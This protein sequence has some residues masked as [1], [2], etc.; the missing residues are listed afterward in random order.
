MQW[1]VL[2]IG[3]CFSAS[4]SLLVKDGMTKKDF[5]ANDFLHL[6]TNWQIWASISL[7]GLAFILYAIVLTR[8]PLNITNPLF[9]AGS[10]VAVCICS[11]IIYK[12]PFNWTT[13]LGIFLII[14]G[15][16]TL[17]RHA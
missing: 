9:T 13:G 12:E 14:A 1:I 15:V 5:V 8:L 11:T 2:L 16:A 3:I 6:I 7:Y 10:V 17:T 4:A